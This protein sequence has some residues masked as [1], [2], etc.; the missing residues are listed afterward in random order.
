MKTSASHHPKRVFMWMTNITRIISAVRA[1]ATTAAATAVAAVAVGV[2]N[3]FVVSMGLSKI[4]VA[5]VTD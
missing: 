2:V 1:G 5:I 3:V 4:A